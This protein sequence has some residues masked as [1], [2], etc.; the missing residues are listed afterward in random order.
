[1]NKYV[2]I[3]NWKKDWIFQDWDKVDCTERNPS[4]CLVMI[5]VWMMWGKGGFGLSI[6]VK[7][8]IVYTI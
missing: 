4:V 7:V 5:G 6:R 8:Y 2:N 1:M 3:E